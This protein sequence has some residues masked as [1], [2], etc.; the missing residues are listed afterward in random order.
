[1]ANV[2]QRLGQRVR[3]LRAQRGY[4]QESLAER[5]KITWHYVSSIERGT[6][7]ATLETLVAITA[8]LDVTL[9]E[10][11]LDVDRPLPREVKRLTAALAGRRTESQRT[12]LRIVE[13]A[14]KLADH[15][16]GS[17][18]RSQASPL[19]RRRERLE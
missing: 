7:G 14:L 17:E 3:E 6:K 15:R 13:E 1:M 19:S 11:F 10:L 9:S 5:A 18:V 2:L 4:T 8:A 16:D 12:I